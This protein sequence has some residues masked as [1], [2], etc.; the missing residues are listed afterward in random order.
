MGL[1]K[2]VLDEKLYDRSWVRRWTN[3]P[4]LIREDT[5]KLLRESDLKPTGSDTNYLA[6]DKQ[7]EAP[8]VWDTQAVA[9]IETDPD[10]VLSGRYEISR[11]D[12]TI[13]K[14]KTVWDG[15][16]AQ[17]AEYPLV[18]VEKIT[19]VPAKDIQAAARLYAKSKPAAIHWGCPLI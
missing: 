3:G 2:V 12:G 14:C 16:Q 19:G 8:V 18:E 9:Y 13:I 15:L 4:H 11:T 10:C 17:V 5:G 7:K 6:W 1:L